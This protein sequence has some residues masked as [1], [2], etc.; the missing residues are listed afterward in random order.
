MHTLRLQNMGLN[1]VEDCPWQPTFDLPCFLHIL[2]FVILFQEL[3]YDIDK[4]KW[5]G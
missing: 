1:P 3:D 5:K 4:I 2:A